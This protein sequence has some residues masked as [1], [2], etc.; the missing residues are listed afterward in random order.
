MVMRPDAVALTQALVR[1]DT[2][3]PPGNED[4]C[5]THL[6]RMLEDAGFR[7]AT[8]AFAP[9]RASLVARIGGSAT[10]APLCFTGHVD[11][12]PLGTAPWRRDPFA[13]EIADG[14]LYGRGSSDM[15]SGVAAFVAA[16]IELAPHLTSGPGVVLV[17]TAGEETGCD[18]A[19]HLARLHEA[20]RILGEAGAIV[21]AEP[22]SNYPLVG[23]KGALWL[24]ATTKGI[25]AHGSMPH[26]GVN[27]IHKAAHAVAALE[28][29]DFGGAPDPLMGSSTLNVGTI[30]GGINVNS[31]PD[32][33][34]I[35]IDIRTIP[36]QR[37]AELLGCL[38]RHLGTDVELAP[39]VDVEAVQTDPEHPWVRR[40]FDV[41]APLLGEPIAPRSVT[42][43]TDAAALRQAY[44]RVPTVIL[45]P[46]EPQLAHQTDEY[47][48]VHRIG[49]AVAADVALIRDWCGI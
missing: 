27:A 18:G 45:G 8:Y 28:R 35:G 46:G 16:A 48:F 33:A 11:V 13:A 40:V 4:Q 20:E 43:F 19:L 39:L 25:T 38:C 26:L 6:G 3:N 23:H 7:C 36:G 32:S 37:H 44:G 29:F 22:T 34:A 10:T 5:T 31:V 47:C 2:I 42:Y 30:R 17:I 49:Q 24:E 12:V 41:M 14:K 9:R 1:M 15:K 21:V